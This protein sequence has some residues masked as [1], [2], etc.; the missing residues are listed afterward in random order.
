M[1]KRLARAIIPEKWHLGNYGPRYL[2]ELVRKRTK[3]RVRTGPFKGL[4]YIDHSLA[5]VYVPK[6][7][8]IYERELHPVIE[9]ASLLHIDHVIDIGAAEGYYAVGMARRFKSAAI[10]AFETDPSGQRAIKELARRNDVESRVN[11]L[12]KCELQD[13]EQAL[14]IGDKHLIV[15]DVEGY[16]ETLLDIDRLPKLRDAFILVELHDFVNR[17]LSDVIRGRFSE[18]HGIAEIW[19]ETRSVRDF[20]FQS[21]HTRLLPNVYI[22]NELN[23]YRPERMSWF[24]M[25][26]I[27]VGPVIVTPGESG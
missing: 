22:E 5:S 3:L 4:K 7:L 25:Q 18:T 23:E 2:N 8:G 26:P 16:E 12:G 24:W 10:T 11:I 15:C 20:P 27:G 19:Q 14:A 1:L 21:L 17:G 9:T 13:L 6:L